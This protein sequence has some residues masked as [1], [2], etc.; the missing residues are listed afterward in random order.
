MHN[1]S[2]ATVGHFQINDNEINATGGYGME[3]NDKF[4]YSL[5]AYMEDSAHAQFEGI[6]VNNNTIKTSGGYNGMYFDSYVLCEVGYYMNLNSPGNSNATFGHFQINGNIITAA[7]A[8]GIGI[9]FQANFAYD[10]AANLYDSANCSIGN[11]EINNNIITASDGDGMYFSAAVLEYVAYDMHG[12]STATFGHVQIN[13]NHI[14]AGG[15]GMYFGSGFAAIMA[16]YMYN[17]THARFG[18]IEV[19]NNTITANGGD[20]MYFN[21]ALYYVGYDMHGTSNA[22]FGHFQ[23]NCNE[24][25]AGGLG[26]HFSQYFASYLASEMYNSSQVQFGEIEVNNNTINATGDGMYFNYGLYEV[27]YSMNYYGP[28]NSTATFGHFQINC[29]NIT[30]GGIGMDFSGE[31]A[32]ELAASM[33]YSARLQ[34]GE[35]EVN[36]NT[37]NATGDGMYFNYVLFEIGYNMEGNS[38]ATLGHFQ[39]NGNEITTTGGI[40]MD[41]EYYFASELAHTMY[42]FARLQ[43]D[44]IE[45]NNNTINATGDGMY[46]YE[47]M[48][49]AGKDMHDT[50]NATFGHFQINDNNITAG[51]IGMNFTYLF[52]YQLAYQMYNSSQAQFGEIEVNNNT[53][54]ATGDDGMYF[55]YVLSAVA[56]SM[57]GNSTAIFG[58]F[59]INGNNIT[60]NGTGMNFDSDGYGYFAYELAYDMDDSSQAQFGEIEVNNNTINAT[61][62]G[63]AF[64][65]VL[66]E[67]GYNMNKD[68]PGNATA[69]F[70]HFQ[71]NGNNITAGGIGMDFSDLFANSVAAYLDY[72]AQVQFGG[73]EVNNNTINATSHGMYFYYVLSEVGSS[74]NQNSP[75]NA[76]ATFE[77]F[78]INDNNITAN[79]TGM[80]FSDD[81]YFAYYLAA[82]LEDSAQVQFGGIEVNNNTI[83][84]AS[85]G[86]YFYYVL[87]RAGRVMHDNA[88]ATFGHFQINDNDITAT[89]GIGMNFS[90]E[91]ANLVAYQMYNSSQAQ[92]GEIEVNNNTINAA[93]DGMFFNEV[94]FQIGSDM[95]GNAT[96]TFGHFQINDNNITA[97]GKGMHFSDGYSYF[98]YELAY[99]ME[100]SAQV[101]F[102]E[103][104][105]NNNTINATSGDGMSFYYVLSEVGHRMHGNSTAIFGHFQ[106][107]DNEIDAGGIGM[108]FSEE[109][110]SYLAA[111]MEDSAQAHFGEIEVNNNTINATGDGMYFYYVLYEVGYSMNDYGP[112][113][114]TAIFGH[115]QINDN[116]ITATGGIGMNFSDYFA[117][118]LATYMED[119]AQVDFGGIE[120][121][122]N[123]INATDDGMAFRDVLFQIGYNMEGNA[124]ATFGHFQ[125]NDNN[126]T[127]NGTGMHFGSTDRQGEFAVYL[128]ADM[129]DSAQAQFG[130]I[131]VNNNT[132]NATS[133]GMSF[134]EVL[135]EV[136]SSMNSNS[137]GNA[138][139]TFGHFQIND[140]EI[141]V[142]GIG[143]NFDSRFAHELAD[144]MYHSAEVQFGE[145]EVNNNTINVTSHGMYFD[146][147]VLTYVGSGMHGTSNAT[148]GHFQ[149][150]DNEIDAGEIGMFFEYPFASWLAGYQMGDS[151]R[152]QFGGI[153]VNNNTINATSD[154]MH[155]GAYVL[156]DLGSEMN[157]DGPGNSTGNFSHF[158]INGNLIIA[159]GDGIYLQNMYGGNNWYGH[160]MN[161]NSSVVI[162]DVQVNNNVITCNASGIYV[163]NS[164]LGVRAPLEDNSSLTMGTVTFNCNTIT[165][166]GSD[167]GIYF[168][169]NNFWITLADAATFT[170]GA[171]LVDGNT[172]FNA[173]YGIYMNDTDNFTISNNYVHDNDHGILLN[174]SNYTT[175]M[176]NMIVNN[177]APVPDTG[178]HVDANSFYNELHRNC[179][180]DNSPQA[181][182]LEITRTN[183][184][185]GNFWSDYNGT[186]AYMFDYNQ[187]NDPLDQCPVSAPLAVMKTID[188]SEPYSP[189]DNIT[190]NITVCNL[191]NMN[192]TN[193]TMIDTV[194]GEFN[195]GTLAPNECN[196]TY[197]YHT[198]TEDD[199]CSGWINNTV[200][201]S[202]RY[203]PYECG[204]TTLYSETTVYSETY[205]NVS[206][207]YVSALN[208]T[209]MVEGA[210]TYYPGD[211]ITYNITVCNLGNLTLENVAVN[212]PQLGL[213][214][215]SLGSLA[216]GNCTTLEWPYRVNETD[217]CMGWINNTVNVSAADTC[218]ITRYNETSANVS[219]EYFAAL[220]VT[221]VAEGAGTYYPGENVTYNITV[222]NLGNLTLENVTVND[223]QLGLVNYSL[224][225]LAPGNCTTLE[226]PYR[227]NETDACTGWINNTVNVSAEDT[228]GITRYNESSA[229][230]SVEYLAALNVTKVAEGAGTYY[231]N[232]KVTYN[233]TVC[234]TGNVTVTNVT[235]NDPLLGVR[236]LGTLG[237]GNCTS[238]KLNHTVNDTDACRGW[239]NNTVNVSAEDI[240][241]EG[242]VTV[243]GEASE[244]VTVL[245]DAA[246]SVTKVAVGSEGPYYP[247][248]T[249]TY[250]IT[251]CN[252]GNVTVRNVMFNDPLLGDPDLGA[253]EPGNCTSREL[254]YRV[255]DTDACRGWINNTVN[256]SAVD[257]CN[258]TIYAEAYENVSTAYNASLN[259]TKE[260]DIVG[261]VAP[262]DTIN[263]TITVCNTG[264]ATI[265]NVTINDSLFG[266][267]TNQSLSKGECWILNTTHNVTQ[268][269]CTGWINNTAQVTGTD[270]CGENVTAVTASWNITVECGNCIRGYKLNESG[271]GLANWTI[272]VKNSTGE[273]IN[274]TT[275]DD[276]GYWQVCNVTPDTYTVCE[277]LQPGW[278][279]IDNETGCLE[280]TFE[281]ANIRN[282]NF[283]NRECN[284]SVSDL[285]WLDTNQNGIQDVDELGLGGV[286][287]RLYRHEEG[288]VTLLN[289]TVTDGSGFYI[290]EKLCAGNYSLKFI[291]PPGYAFTQPDQGGDTEDSDVDP[292]TGSTG[293][294][295]LGD[296]VV[297]TT[298][299][300][301]LYLFTQAPAFTAGG[302]FALV[303]ILA[304]I[305]VLSVRRKRH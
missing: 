11:F 240:C 136:G 133:H 50:S 270:Y 32:K 109:F 33:D 28:G 163:N 185:T 267:F 9:Y 37:I 275:T 203:T 244:N 30:A 293:V 213:V 229:N 63:M 51:G 8:G 41:F 183:N 137:L 187:D 188:S 231:L 146:D 152:V 288:N 34:F 47:I 27:G 55:Y 36:N 253:I 281:A 66:Y 291:P 82:Y 115:F 265:M 38:T 84:A 114:S 23:I 198:V 62:D 18:E 25:D 119:F 243:F 31:F 245:S 128:A 2:T 156:Y 263:Y 277:V 59:Q 292:G 101:Q 91:F 79:G 126:I 303:S 264:N 224:G 120:V 96:A 123:T 177:T 235:V 141:D 248:D 271:V 104:E 181:I 296:G 76:T 162:G 202:A 157:Y 60:A 242:V 110:A 276:T 130:E 206:V 250:N 65:E 210:G 171:L 26:M 189:G 164:D 72:S 14:D 89:G 298:I 166:N 69:T 247:G 278:E 196:W 17:S 173:E 94:L 56:Y 15:E 45:V 176:Y 54:N 39:I 10:L 102:G 220:S 259:I 215:Y 61:G 238:V 285:V 131:E 223:P 97:S 159:G 22:T 64:Q 112:G 204:Y 35:I 286:T 135:Y 5:A 172:I 108:R 40:G 279:I 117:Y 142:G 174:A 256:A 299:D 129:E 106:I 127:A 92:F 139:A 16:Y 6:E 234:N 268:D 1:Y 153:E 274:E 140:N 67:V 46:F 184:W 222:C 58:H 262:G 95:E 251:V 80:H 170:V 13:D 239:I 90:D 12:T 75:G 48:D 294:F 190:Y 24:I 295:T 98:A 7:G 116:E 154:G 252:T 179:F 193:V 178:A 74:M 169:L 249:V 227:V 194:L 237:P 20:G 273:I 304:T 87:E 236:E 195:I 225:T 71:I 118:G 100:D 214:N 144:E 165:C 78:Q 232:E 192:L 132:I 216:P 305:A 148:F 86:M 168:Y 113:N 200:N 301:G 219:V 77:H 125:I 182:D 241:N 57:E 107:N 218:G 138:T 68:G 88:T 300:A 42:D 49:L 228:C 254:N 280:I 289:T 272:T 43:F 151:A 158:Q 207:E 19:N 52:A 282:L 221:K 161:E 205:K 191:G 269:D 284:G 124:T 105:V 83:N 290:F 147:D 160:A 233:I 287:V 44:S 21:D 134:Y 149:I 297:D 70:R 53:I 283:T 257:I 111:D 81:G 99:D 226:W 73:I 258:E 167:Y 93:S 180:I 260:A 121:N 266:T 302:L 217:A 246:I 29:N 199:A 103:I 230:V 208:V 143:M 155:Y 3:F 212:D 255:N 261:P 197:H 122:N 85:D 209:K 201:A 211:M 4:A 150:N 145:I 186:G 175:V